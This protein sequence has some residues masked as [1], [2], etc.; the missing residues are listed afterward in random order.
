MLRMRGEDGE[1]EG[2]AEIARQVEQAG[3]VLDAL[4]RQGAE[5]QHARRHHAEHHAEAAHRL[6]REQLPIGPVLGDRHQLEA[7][8]AEEPEA[9]GDEHA[10]IDLGRE[11]AD[12]RRGQHHEGAG[13]PD[14]VADLLGVV[15]AHARQERSAA[16]R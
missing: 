13:D 11:G 4:R 5:R 3:G 12:D 16:G 7:G 14:R 10:R 15:A 2:A 6:S 1:A 9:D 8:D